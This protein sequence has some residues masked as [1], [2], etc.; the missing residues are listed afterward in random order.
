MKPSMALAEAQREYGVRPLADEPH[1]GIY[2][3]IILA[4][5]HPEVLEMG[6]AGIH[7]FGKPEHVLYD[8]KFRRGNVE[9]DEHL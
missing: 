7:V 3:A 8:A 9:V 4:A 1:A 6:A 2:D 5:A